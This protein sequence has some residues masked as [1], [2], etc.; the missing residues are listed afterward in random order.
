MSR[1]KII[2][3]I[4]Q[5]S[6]DPEIV[7]E[8][9]SFGQE[10]KLAKGDYHGFAFYQDKPEVGVER[11]LIVFGPYFEGMIPTEMFGKLLEIKLEIKLAEEAER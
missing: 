8:V 7:Q 4:N 10:M 3:R 2:G 5:D 9:G 11:T 6:G 1:G